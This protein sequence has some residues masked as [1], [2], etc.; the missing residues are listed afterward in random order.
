[1]ARTAVELESGVVAYLW[2]DRAAR[3]YGHDGI[4]PSGGVAT[5]R[6]LR[7]QT[8]NPNGRTQRGRATGGTVELSGRF[9]QR[10]TRRRRPPVH[11]PRS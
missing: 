2:L 9:R 8:V 4:E 11:S 5:R 6:S 1:M 3:W 7:T 10:T